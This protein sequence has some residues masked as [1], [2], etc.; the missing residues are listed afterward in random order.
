MH[1]LEGAADSLPRVP[2]EPLGSICSVELGQLDKLFVN[3]GKAL[4]ETERD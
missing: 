2:A 3:F 1:V 4:G